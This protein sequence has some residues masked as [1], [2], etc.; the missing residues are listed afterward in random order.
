M[1]RQRLDYACDVLVVGADYL[2]GKTGDFE[3]IREDIKPIPR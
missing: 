3:M 2:D 1:I